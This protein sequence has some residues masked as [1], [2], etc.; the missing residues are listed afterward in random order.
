MRPRV[1]SADITGPQ[2]HDPEDVLIR[3]LLHLTEVCRQIHTETELF[4][5]QLNEFRIA[6]DH[7]MKYFINALSEKHLGVVRTYVWPRK[8]GMVKDDMLSKFTGLER[9]VLQVHPE[10]I[11]GDDFY[12]PVNATEKVVRWYRERRVIARNRTKA[13]EAKGITIQ[14]YKRTDLSKGFAESKTCSMS[15]MVHHRL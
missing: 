1:Y 11:G 10:P 12:V 14:N 15:T 6:G 5:F 2:F 13:W 8:C 7:N 4:I 9:I 3:K